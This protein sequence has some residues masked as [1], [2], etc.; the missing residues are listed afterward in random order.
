MKVILTI[1]DGPQK[2]KIFEFAEPDNFLLGRNAEGS[3]AHFRLS[4]KDTYVS[5]NH[6]LLE[7]NPPDCFLRDAGSLNGTFIVRPDE[8]AVYF[9]PGREEKKEDYAQKAE[10]LQKKLNYHSFRQAE[11]RIG[12][13]DK[14]I[15]TVGGTSILVDVFQNSGDSPQFLISEYPHDGGIARCIECSKEIKLHEIPKSPDKLSHQDFLCDV[16]LKKRI[17]AHYHKQVFPCCECQKDI[18]AFANKDGKEGNL[19]EVAI[20]CCESC[21]QSYPRDQLLVADIQDYRLLRKIGSGGF[22]V[23]YFAW[24]KPTRR[25]AA[26]KLTKEAIKKDAQLIKRFKREI[27]IM[28][29]LAHPNLVRLYDEGITEEGQYYFVSEF[30]RSG[31]LGDY[32]FRHYNGRM[33]YQMACSLIA[34]ALDGLCYFHEKG[35]VHR[36]IKPENILLAKTS[37]AEYIA[38]IGDFGLARSYVLHG[39]TLTRGNE[40][41]GTVLFCPPEQIL[42]FRNAHPCSDV[43]ALGMSLYYIISGQFPYEFP[44][45]EEFNAL[46]RKGKKPRDPI[47]FILGKDKPIPIG[48]KIGDIPKNFADAINRAIEKDMKKRI[49][50]AEEFKKILEKTIS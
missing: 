32:C 18:S 31:S 34:Q 10:S 28:Q 26:L 29:N 21:I 35:F 23:V 9:L 3:R 7:I 6:F 43:Y 27:A 14:D 30:L 38:K 5:R 42:D 19:R 44:N 1:V 48:K 36:D 37:K 4:A 11:E 22:G 24:H 45:R 12:L 17:K 8:K 2:G 20:Y 16:C 25:I 33:P 47:S 49:N 40:W 46:L 41:I 39:G 13:K 50:S 15:I